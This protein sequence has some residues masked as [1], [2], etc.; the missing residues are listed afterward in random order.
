MR[1]QRDHEIE[2][3]GIMQ[4]FDQ[5]AKELGQGNRARVVRDEHEDA[6]ARVLPG[7]R[8]V[9]HL[10]NRV[11]VRC[12]GEVA[13]ASMGFLNND[14]CGSGMLFRATVGLLSERLS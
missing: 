9:E 12:V 2:L 4:Q 11:R 1:A 13:C 5:Q 8:L 7:E 6:L 3:T 14:L 10:L